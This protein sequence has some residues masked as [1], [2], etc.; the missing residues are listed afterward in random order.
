LVVGQPLPLDEAQELNNAASNKK[1]A[2]KIIIFF[3]EINDG[4]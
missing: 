3:I 4:Y 2:E 1:Q